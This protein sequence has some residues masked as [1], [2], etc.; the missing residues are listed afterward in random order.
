MKNLV[1]KIKRWNIK[2]KINNCYDDYE[3]LHRFEQFEC[4]E[5]FRGFESARRNRKIAH[6]WQHEIDEL[7]DKL[8]KQLKE[9]K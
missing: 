2:R 5:F 8:E 3:S 6:K 4:C 1:K 9:L 7:L